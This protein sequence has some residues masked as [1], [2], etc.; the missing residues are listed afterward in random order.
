MMGWRNVLLRAMVAAFATFIAIPALAQ[1]Y[2]IAALT[3]NRPHFG[4]VAGQPGTATTSI[5]IN[6]AGTAVTSTSPSSGVVVNGTGRITQTISITCS[7]PCS[8]TTRAI[9]IVAGAGTNRMGTISD[10]VLAAGTGT[11]IS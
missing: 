1:T 3:A 11:I 4:V 7:R 6:P 10:M 2:N 9:T 8:G 5:T